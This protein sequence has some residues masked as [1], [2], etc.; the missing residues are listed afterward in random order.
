VRDKFST[1][2]VLTIGKEN[3]VL[4]WILD[5]SLDLFWIWRLIHEVMGRLYGAC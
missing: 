5:F 2:A 1:P 4:N 3:P